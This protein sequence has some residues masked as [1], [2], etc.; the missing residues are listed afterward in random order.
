MD[1]FNFETGDLLLFNGNDFSFPL[2]FF[3]FIIK[4]FTDSDWSHIGM[5]VKDPT[6][7]NLPKGVYLWQSS[8]EENAENGKMTLGVELTP[9]EKIIKEYDGIIHWRKLNSGNVK[10]TNEKLEEI[11]NLVHN[12]PYD[13]NP[14]DWFDALIEHKSTRKT[15]RYFCSALIARIYSFLD[16]ISPNIDWTII[17]PSS[18]SQENPDDSTHIELINEAYL[19][20][21][22]K[23]N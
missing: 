12:K 4:L 8:F 6:F 7:G 3:S 2:G 20:P 13:L 18:F 23:I 5:I 10:I 19:Y 21:E 17:R 14:F 1:I 9:I 22:I 11:H 16:L 15:S